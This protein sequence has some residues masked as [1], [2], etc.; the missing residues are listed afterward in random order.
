[1]F[2]QIECKNLFILSLLFISFFLVFLSIEK[3][4]ASSIDPASTESIDNENLPIIKEKKSIQSEDSVY[5]DT[6]GLYTEEDFKNAIPVE[7]IEN[8]PTDLTPSQEIQ[9]K[10][11]EYAPPTPPIESNISTKSV[12]PKT[13]GKLFFKKPSSSSTY[14]CSASVINSNAD[15][16]VLTAGHCVHGNGSWYK[17]FVF[18]PAYY[19][20]EHPYGSWIWE[21]VQAPAGWTQ[22]KNYSYDKAVIRISPNNGNEIERYLGANGWITNID[23]AQSNVRIT[24][25]P[26]DPPYTG[27]LPHSCYG[28]TNK[29]SG[30]DAFMNCNFTGGSSGGAWFDQMSSEDLGIIF[31]ATSRGTSFIVPRLLATPLGDEFTNMLKN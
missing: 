7:Q 30:T 12:V 22:S 3:V 27:E 20:G 2:K 24:G 8:F 29:Y 17:D 19:N 1:M 14:V 18:V 16:A 26:A 6:G 23:P 28:D 5:Q 4:S 9:S 15:N 25:Y 11:K 13:T 21:R 10:K 31:A